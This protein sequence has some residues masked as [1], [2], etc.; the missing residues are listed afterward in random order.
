M[1]LP[2]ALNEKHRQNKGKSIQGGIFIK[3]ERKTPIFIIK[4]SKLLRRV[5]QSHN[6]LHELQEKLRNH[7]SGFKGEQSLDY[8]YRYLPKDV[9]L[10]HGMRILHDD[11]YFQMDTLLISP[12]FIT[13]LEVKYLAGSLFFEN[14]FSQLIR[15][16]NDKRDSFTNPIEQVN[17]QKYHLSKILEQNKFTAVPIETLVVITH[18]SAII[19]ASPT[20]KEALERVIKSSNL[21]QKFENLTRKHPTPV[22]AQKQIK[23]LI[24]LLSKISS[25]YDPDVCEL[26][27]IKKAELI[28]GVLCITCTHSTLRYVRGTWYCPVCNTSSKTAHIEAL[29]DYACLISTNI[30]TKACKDFLKLSSNKQ[31]YNILCSLKLPY[32]GNRKS[33]YYHLTPLLENLQ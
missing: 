28:S 17:R 25:L 21:P 6:R 10:L 4:L 14:R 22:L 5:P 29:E 26:F 33:R 1:I 31:A 8:F 13:I 24:K 7:T 20:Y 9:H 32:T 2:F 15:T 3:N 12:S 27:Q 11:Y 16:Y 18:P 23:K 19:D 30:T